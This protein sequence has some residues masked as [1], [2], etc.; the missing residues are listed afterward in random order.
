MK[1]TARPKHTST[2]AILIK[3]LEIAQAQHD[4]LLILGNNLIAEI[5][6]EI[7]IG[8]IKNS[9]ALDIRVSD[10]RDLIAKAEPTK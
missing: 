8:E 2:V 6:H 5:E 1:H 4:A 10:L 7:E 3:R 9:T